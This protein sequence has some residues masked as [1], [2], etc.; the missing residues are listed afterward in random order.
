MFFKN[1]KS[2][3]KKLINRSNANTGQEHSPYI[4]VTEINNTPNA[5]FTKPDLIH[6][7]L[8][9]NRKANAL[10]ILAK[11]NDQPIQVTIDTGAN[12]NCIR[13]DLIDTNNIKISHRYQ[14]SGPDQTPLQLLGTTN[15][16]LQIDKHQFHIT[17]CVIKNLSSTIILGNEFMSK[18][19]AKINF[20]KQTLTLNNNVKTKIM[21]NK[22]PQI[23]KISENTTDTS[24]PINTITEQKINILDAPKIFSITH[25]ISADLFHTPISKEISEIYGDH[26]SHIITNTSLIPGQITTIKTDDRL[27]HYLINKED[28]KSYISYLDIYE[29]LYRLKEQAISKNYTHIAFSITNLT[30]NKLEW[31][32]IKDMLTEIYSHTNLQILICNDTDIKEPNKNFISNI[33]TTYNNIMNK[34]NKETHQNNE[35]NK[36]IDVFSNY[37]VGEK[38][39][40]DGNC[41]IY[42][43]I[44]AVNDNKSHYITSIAHILELLQLKNLPKY[45]LHDDEIASLANFYN[46]D[47]YIYSDRTTN[48]L[49]YG[50]GHRQPIVL[51]H[52]DN[53]THWYPGTIIKNNKTS[54]KIP[55]T[56]THITNYTPLENIRKEIHTFL[57][58]EH[59]TINAINT[60]EKSKIFDN[61]GTQINIAE[62]LTIDQH[63]K[64]LELLQKYIHIFTTDTTK[65]KAAR[66]EPCKIS[67]KPDYK[68]PKFN[69]PHRVSPAQRIELKN[70]LDKLLQA[71]IIEHTKSNFAAPAFL[72]HKKEKNTYRLVVSFK[73]LNKIVLPDQYP[74]PRTTDLFRSLEG[75]QFFTSLDLNNGFFQIPVREEDQDKLSF[76][77]THGLMRFKRVPQGY[78]NSSAIFQRELNKAFSDILYKSVIIF[79][80]D[81]AT[82]GKDFK[83][84]LDNLQQVFQIIDQYGFSLKTAKCKI[85]S[86][87]IELLGHEISIYGLKPL[88]RNTDAITNFQRPKT[89]KQVRSFLGMCS[90]YRRLVKNFSIIA[91]PLFDL[92]KHDTTKIDWKDEHET[93]FNKL[94]TILTS[95]PVITHFSDDKETFLTVDAS[96]IGLGAV[97]E[98]P[99]DSQKLRPIGYASRKVLESEKTYS[100]TTL[101]LLGLV[102]GV[103]YFREFLWGRKFIVYSDNISLQYYTN[104]KIPSARIARLT[105]KLLDFDFTIIHKKG[106]ENLVADCLSREHIMFIIDAVIFDNYSHNNNQEIIQ[107]TTVSDIN[108]IEHQQNDKLCSEIIKAINGKNTSDK[109]KKL[110]RKYTLHNQILYFKRHSP[111]HNIENAIVIPATLVERVITAYHTQPLA[112]HLGTSKT[113]KTIQIK[114]YWP[115][116]I[117]DVT[118]YIK[119]C[120]KCQINKKMPGKPVGNLQPIQLASCQPITRI[121]MDFLGPLVNSNNKNYILVFTCQS[122]KFV[123]AKA[124]RSA[125]ANIVVKTLILFITQY[126]IPRYLTSD[127]G[128]HFKNKTLGEVCTNLGIKQIFSSS[129]A[130]Q[131]QGFT[132]K[133]N[134]VICQAIRHYIKENN[135][136]RWSYYLPYII[137]AYNNSI[138]TSTKYTPFYLLHGFNANTTIDSQIIPENLS[139]DI[140]KSLEELKIVRQQ[141]PEYIKK[142]QITQKLNHDRKH[143]LMTYEPNQ[144]VLVEFPFQEKNKCSKLTQKYKGPFKI[145][146]KIS[147]V[148]Y[149]VEL[150][151]Y[152]R[153]ARDV[154]HIRRLKPYFQREQTGST[155]E[156]K[157]DEEKEQK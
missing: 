94:K 70:Q 88:T 147:D 44:N 43:L 106:K 22:L 137:F 42:A 85:F 75:S 132:E 11:L 143:K 15:I 87:K 96:L 60:N 125:D 142:A 3:S 121:T 116:L 1:P 66:V 25:C 120:H 104:L 135:Q 26:T 109:F 9:E 48:G 134:G 27:I 118:H 155:A 73:E 136:S 92:T 37:K 21:N 69:S 23:T 111:N 81:L 140:K 18:N 105:L 55:L 31:Q 54:N 53:G 67:L 77:T 65:I 151:L 12:I 124:T 83:I 89:P 57:S 115:T 157:S 133:I 93:A 146:S 107:Q 51:Y 138:Q 86:E 117:K 84:A 79:I 102:F 80:D 113:I 33:K 144:L 150:I 100:S 130:P 90:Y 59:Q 7:I 63:N 28:H 52:L 126:G 5:N 153:L 8:N 68:E 129:Y 131:S 14:L 64:T 95:E 82:F 72:V 76:I 99:D 13:P 6:I 56:I 62:H 156:D 20:K 61:E 38:V 110:S 103:T 78:R 148:S 154:I 123:F 10:Y 17:A 91:H 29:N 108:I 40:S 47:T 114:Y 34:N 49:V 35:Q 101:E 145:V 36:F 2:K 41:G 139:Y 39:I 152:N 149:L 46:F 4:P 58:S 30:D 127:R 71:D 32:I 141:I 74:L 128:S 112:A 16:T 45:W 119:T 50:T 98:Q 19:N 97:L 122:S 24:K